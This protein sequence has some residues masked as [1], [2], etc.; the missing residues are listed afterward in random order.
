MIAS[1]TTLHIVLSVLILTFSVAAIANYSEPTIQEYKV[2][3]VGAWRTIIAEYDAIETSEPNGRQA[4]RVFDFL[5]ECSMAAF[6]SFPPQISTLVY[7]MFSDFG[8]EKGSKAFDEAARD[9]E[10]DIS[11]AVR[12][13]VSDTGYSIEWFDSA[14][15]TLKTIMRGCQ[16]QIAKDPM[17][18]K[19]T[20]LSNTGVISSTHKHRPELNAKAES[21]S[22]LEAEYTLAKRS[23]L[24][25]LA[26]LKNEDPNAFQ[27]VEVA[28]AAA[29]NCMLAS[30]SVY[31]FDLRR[32]IIQDIHTFGFEYHG[33]SLVQIINYEPNL[34]KY[35][36][37]RASINQM[38]DSK[39]HINQ[40][41]RLAME[42]NPEL[43]GM[44]A[45]EFN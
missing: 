15:L 31:P 20:E 21:V 28:T 10:S 44:P 36:V 16:L 39:N 6:S 37:T 1:K 27:G 19:A 18:F 32:R 24:A 41:C 2:A 29:V 14:N 13:Y 42:E 7:K 26:P 34:E 3:E 22:A 40:G 45:S 17:Q 25:S 33:S 4:T 11:K 35:G 23:I 38:W 30:F 9:P 12:A 43:Y 5:T 8:F